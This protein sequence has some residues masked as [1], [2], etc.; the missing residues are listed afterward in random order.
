M[1]C[2]LFAGF[3]ECDD[4]EFVGRRR[5]SAHYPDT[6]SVAYKEYNKTM[7]VYVPRRP[8]IYDNSYNGK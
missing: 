3:Q 2:W 4:F 5:R 6:D 1:I 8:R 7:Q